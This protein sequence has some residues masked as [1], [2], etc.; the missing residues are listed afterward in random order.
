MDFGLEYR[1]SEGIKLVGYTDSDWAGSVA[2]R[3]STSGCCFSLGSAIVSWFS[4]K[5]KSVA[6]SSAEAEYMATS[7]ASCEVLWL[8]KLLV[9]LFG[10]E[11]RPTVIYCDNQSC[12]QL[13]ENLVFHD[14]S[15]HIEIRYH[16][17]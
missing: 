4:Q 3:K 12:I 1:R 17:I 5:Q 2:N 8:C 11:L 7:H 6:L 10:Q 13:S 9:N 14:R 16:F 15:K